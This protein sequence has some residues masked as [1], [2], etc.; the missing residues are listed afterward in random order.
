MS[1]LIF[2]IFSHFLFKSSVAKL[3]CIKLYVPAEPQHM[4]PSGTSNTLLPVI[5]KSAI[6]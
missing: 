6:G 4:C 1:G 2:L 5:F 3:S